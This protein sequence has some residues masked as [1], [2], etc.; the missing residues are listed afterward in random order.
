MQK[1]TPNNSYDEGLVKQFRVNV[2]VST[3]VYRATDMRGEP[4]ICGPRRL[5]IP[6]KHSFTLPNRRVPVITRAGAPL[7]PWTDD[8]PVTL[9]RDCRGL[10]HHYFPNYGFGYTGRED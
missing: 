5:K 10:A 7:T 4:V 3:M 9:G 6:Y 2:R 8:Q 1:K